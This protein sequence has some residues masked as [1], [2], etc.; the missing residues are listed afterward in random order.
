MTK[1]NRVPRQNGA[2]TFP[3]ERRQAASRRD[4]KFLGRFSVTF[5][6]RCFFSPLEAHGVPAT[7]PITTTMK[8]KQILIAWL[9]FSALGVAATALAQP[10]ITT[11]PRT[12]FQWE[13]KRVSLEVRATGTAPFRY[14]WQFNGADLPGATN[15]VFNLPRVQLTNDGNYQ[16][17][18]TDGSGGVT[19]SEVAR[20]MVRAWPEPTGPTIPELTRLD[21]ALQNVMLANA[22]PG[23]SLAVVKDGRL[24]LARGYGFAEVETHERYQPDSLWRSDSLAKTITAAAYMQLVEQGKANLDTPVLDILKLEPPTYPGAAFDSRWT[25]VTARLALLHAGGW[26]EDAAKDPLGATGFSPVF[27]PNQIAKDL[28]IT[29]PVARFDLICWMLGK[30]MQFKPGT[31]S[32]YGNFGYEVV[33]TLIEILSGSSYEAACQQFLAK[34][35][36]TRMQLGHLKRSDRRPGEVVYYLHPT[37]TPAWLRETAEPIPFNFD[38]PY[39]SLPPQDDYYPLFPASGGWLVS[40]IDYARLVAALDRDSVYPDILADTTLAD[41]AAPS[42]WQNDSPQLRGRYRSLGWLGVDP[43]TGVWARIG[44]GVASRSYAFKYK[45]GV[46]V[47]Y[48]FNSYWFDANGVD[49]QGGVIWSSVASTLDAIRQWPAHDLFPATLSYDAWRANRFT[50]GELGDSAISGDDADPDGDGVSNL[51]EYATGTD[52]H[53]TSEPPRLAASLVEGETP[54]LSLTYRRLLLA[55]EVEYT[56]EDSADL[57]HWSPSVVERDDLGLNADGTVTARV[58][59]KLSQPGRFFRLKLTRRAQ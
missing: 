48:N 13:N 47:V 20:V 10:V 54:T 11:P 35:N 33:G 9:R 18:V 52:P 25:N 7:G 49:N 22:V 3:C 15:R 31:A 40:A 32:N 16:V 6:R 28:N 1:G 26:N 50:S 51:W 29:R 2:L 53:A 34:A 24:V 5:S 59:A 46:I 57:T 37:I 45:N 55:H 4:A 44:G 12:Q 17:V 19:P 39:L 21:T 36:I 27:W 30:P 56:L 58:A 41:M 14:Q 38:A 43:A 8:A 23:A 42:K